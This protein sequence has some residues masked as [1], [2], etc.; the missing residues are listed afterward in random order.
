MKVYIGPYCNWV[1]PYQ[2]AEKILF[3]MDKDEDRRVHKFGEWLATNGSGEPSWLAKLCA[4]IHSKQERKIKIKIHNYDCWSMDSTLALIIL[5]MLIR[6]K[7]A[8]HGAPNVDDADVPEELRSTSAPPTENEWDTDGNH[9]KRWDYVLDEM[10]WAFTQKN[11][12]DNGE[13]PYRKGESHILFQAV[14]KDG[15]KLGEPHEIGESPEGTDE[16]T[17]FEMVK[18]PKNTM[19]TDYEG[20]KLHWARIQNGCRL[21]GVYYQNLWD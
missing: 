16:A 18:G 7:E 5:P 19:E 3:W 8:K 17:M 10:I 9:F 12:D 15:N 20:L 21:F 4:W 6:L 11:D 2:I 14:D 13:T 1:G